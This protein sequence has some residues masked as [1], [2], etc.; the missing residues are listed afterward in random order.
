M[1]PFNCSLLVLSLSFSKPFNCFL[2]VLFLFLSLLLA[3]SIH[4]FA[5]SYCEATNATTK[6]RLL[7]LYQFWLAEICTCHK[8]R[9]TRDET[10]DLQIALP[11]TP[12]LLF[13]LFVFSILLVLHT[14]DTL[15]LVSNF[16]I[17]HFARHFLLLSF[18]GVLW[19]EFN[20]HS[21][22]VT[23][24]F[25]CSF[26]SPPVCFGVF[27]PAEDGCW[28]HENVSCFAFIYS[29]L[30]VVSL[31]DEPWLAYRRQQSAGSTFQF[32]YNQVS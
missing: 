22:I 16:E 12:M 26:G 25:S 15:G 11:M 9:P 17:G 29:M 18:G 32:H 7:L 30:L 24:Y 23:F 31:N 21:F 14:Q 5:E 28:I 4:W 27:Y 2:P 19:K 6:L 13:C 3:T 8:P 1:K 10:R 20:S